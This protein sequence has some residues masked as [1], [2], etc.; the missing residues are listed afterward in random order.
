MGAILHTTAA[1]CRFV[2]CNVGNKVVIVFRTV[3]TP[4][5][6]TAR[7]HWYTV[8]SFFGGI[9]GRKCA[10]QRFNGQNKINQ[11]YQLLSQYIMGRAACQRLCEFD[12]VKKSV[13]CI[14]QH[15]AR[16]YV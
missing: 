5:M 8:A 13:F 12:Y 2:G 9:T 14:V 6:G 10:T 16:K 11:V 15:L 1:Y 4:R 3:F 7:I